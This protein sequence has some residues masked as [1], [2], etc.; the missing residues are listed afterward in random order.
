MITDGPLDSAACQRLARRAGLGL[1]RTASPA[2]HGSGEIFLALATGLRSPRGSAP[3]GVPVTGSALDDYFAA[4]TEA[5]EEA[6]I[7][8]MLQAVTVTGRD[9][10]TSRQIPPTRC[11]RWSPSTG[12]VSVMAGERRGGAGRPAAPRACPRRAPARAATRAPD[13]Y[14]WMRDHDRPALREYL[15]AE[16]AYYDSRRPGGAGCRT[17]C[18]RADRAGARGRGSVRWRRGGREYFTRTVA[19]PGIRAVLPGRAPGA[20]DEVLLDENLLLADPACPGGYVALGVRE[21]S[22]DGRLLAY[23]VDFDGDEVYQLRVRDLATGQDLPERIERTYYGLAWAAD[24][25]R[26]STRSPT[27]R[28]GRSRSGAMS[29]APGRTP[30]SWCTGRTTSGSSSSSGPPA[31]AGTC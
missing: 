7:N 12:G 9:G 17:S 8:S 5:T 2:H 18:A 23:S 1:A 15:T 29:S 30:T 13:P 10:N 27:R 31:A 14:A 22:P 16:R 21:V 28:T 3:S 25:R 24:S 19:R 4:V 6:V 26:C 20:P 11:A